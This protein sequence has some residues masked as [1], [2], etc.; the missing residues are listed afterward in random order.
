MRCD[1]DTFRFAVLINVISRPSPVVICTG[2]QKMKYLAAYLMAVL[3][4][5]NNPEEKDVSQ[6]LESVGTKVDGARLSAL[7]KELKGKVR[8]I[9]ASPPV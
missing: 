6:I 5:N 4:G 7:V 2:R 8:D 3:A 9:A 1:C